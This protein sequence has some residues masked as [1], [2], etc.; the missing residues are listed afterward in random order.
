MKALQREDLM[1][2]RE[3]VSR[4]VALSESLA[5]H[6][7]GNQVG[8]GLWRLFSETFPSGGVRIWNEAIVWKHAWGLTADVF[9]A[10]GEDLFG[11]QLVI[12]SHSEVAMLWNHESGELVDLVLPPL[13]LLDTCLDSGLGWIDF[14]AAAVLEVGRVRASDVSEDRH[15]HWTTPLIL[16]GTPIPSNTSLVDRREHLLGHADLWRQLSGLDLGAVVIPKPSPS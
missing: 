13:E 4:G 8:D 15:L 3:A 10:F 5:K 16:G 2:C 14:Y 12:P 1:R 9:F 11:N 7:G 6:A